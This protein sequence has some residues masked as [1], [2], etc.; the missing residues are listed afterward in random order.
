MSTRKFY[1]TII[2]VTVLSDSPL[3]PMSLGELSYET[4]EG[5]LSAT[6]DTKKEIVLNGKEAADALKEQGSDPEFFQ[7]DEDGNDID[8]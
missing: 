7:I 6:L 1:K 8:G 4:M 5:D 3:Q 2:E